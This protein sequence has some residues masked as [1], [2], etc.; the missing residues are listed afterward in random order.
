MKILE[1]AFDISD[2][3]YLE[4]VKIENTTSQRLTNKNAFHK[5]A[6][7]LAQRQMVIYTFSSHEQK[8]SR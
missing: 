8:T 7:C 3:L 1:G 2:V 4:L 5:I 6:M